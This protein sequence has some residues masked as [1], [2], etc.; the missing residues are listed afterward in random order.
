M[1]DRASLAGTG[2]SI[3]G[4]NDAWHATHLRIAGRG[5]GEPG[6][7]PRQLGHSEPDHPAVHLHDWGRGPEMAGASDLLMVNQ[8]NLASAP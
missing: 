4:G 6:R 2:S 1:G 7:A 5:F 8:R 3:G